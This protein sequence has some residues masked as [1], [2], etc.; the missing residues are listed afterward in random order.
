MNRTTDF[1]NYK[2][3]CHAVGKLM[4]GV[5]VGLTPKQEETFQAYDARYKGEGRKLTENQQADYFA[6]GAKKK[7]KPELSVTAK[8]Y[9]KELWRSEFL[10]RTNHVMS[11]YIDKGLMVESQAITSYSGISGMPFFKN[12]ERKS[13][14]YLTGCPDNTYGKIRD[15]KSSWSLDT[16]P[17]TDKGVEN[18]DYDWQLQ[19][20]MDL[21]NYEESELIYC[22]VDTPFHMIEDELRRMDWKHD[23]FDM[24]GDVRKSRI[25]LI[26]ETIPKH[27]FTH[28]GLEEFCQQ[29]ASIRIEWFDDFVPIPDELRVKKFHVN[30]DKKMIETLYE[31]IK[32]ARAYMNSLSESVAEHLKVEA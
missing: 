30:R 6:L 9:L 26:Q 13:N 17:L 19:S 10:G 12:K 1:S 11:K 16:F 31:Q 3:R 8:N 4:T 23:I 22:L 27:I 28:K 20:Y 5:S 15:I 29:S 7:A 2:F 25:D 32:K 18:K 21:W 24:A 14:D